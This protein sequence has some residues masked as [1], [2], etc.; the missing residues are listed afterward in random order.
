MSST[1]DDSVADYLKKHEIT[2][3]GS[4]IPPPVVNFQ[5]AS[6]PENILNFVVKKFDAP[7]PIQAQVS[8]GGCKLR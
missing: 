3:D 8:A 6:L 1:T 5:E 7:T 4:D 2:V